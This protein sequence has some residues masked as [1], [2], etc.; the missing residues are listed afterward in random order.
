ML[1][2]M[3]IR[4]GCQSNRAALQRCINVCLIYFFID[5]SLLQPKSLMMHSL[6]DSFS[7]SLFLKQDQQL[8][9]VISL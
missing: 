5:L 8:P 1:Y 4:L 6:N 2:R 7:H 3:R 9:N